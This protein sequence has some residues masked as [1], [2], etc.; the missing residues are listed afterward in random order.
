[1]LQKSLSTEEKKELIRQALTARERSYSPYS[2]YQ[3]GA[4]VMTTE[5][6]IYTGCNIENAAYTPTNCAEQTAIFKAVSEG[7]REF[8][9]IAVAGSPKGPVTQYAFPCGVCRQVMREFAKPEQML[10]LVAKS[11]TDYIEKTLA[12]LLPESFGPENLYQ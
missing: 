6:D 12:E 7:A 2:G 9:A 11:E 1:M 4:A 3:V 8:I 10:I 5:R